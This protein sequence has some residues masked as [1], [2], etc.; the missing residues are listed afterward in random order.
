MH[1]LQYASKLPNVTT[2]R[3]IHS[4][5]LLSYHDAADNSKLQ[6]PQLQTQVTATAAASVQDAHLAAGFGENTTRRAATKVC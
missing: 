4:E 5:I 1:D 2:L 3:Y 6:P